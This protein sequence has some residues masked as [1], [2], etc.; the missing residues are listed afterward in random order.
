MVTLRRVGVSLARTMPLPASVT[1][2][3]GVFIPSL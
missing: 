1:V 2:K 3:L